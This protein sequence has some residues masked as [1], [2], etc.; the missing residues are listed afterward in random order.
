MVSRRDKAEIEPYGPEVSAS[1][2]A[3]DVEVTSPV[4]YAFFQPG[5]Y[6]VSNQGCAEARI[7]RWCERTPPSQTECESE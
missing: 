5:T 3:V 2:E 7:F 1:E 4:R 6:E